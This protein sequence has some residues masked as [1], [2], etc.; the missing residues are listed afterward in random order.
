MVSLRKLPQ[1]KR[2]GL[3]SLGITEKLRRKQFRSHANSDIIMSQYTVVMLIELSLAI[4]AENK[5]SMGI[6]KYPQYI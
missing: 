6:Y 1:G 2:S 5:L 3:E 4:L